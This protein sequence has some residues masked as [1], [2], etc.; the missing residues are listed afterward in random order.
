MTETP[1][2]YSE[3]RRVIAQKLEPYF[4]ISSMVP[5]NAASA[6]EPGM[7]EN[8]LVCSWADPETLTNRTLSVFVDPVPDGSQKA[9]D[10]REMIAEETLPTPDAHPSDAEAY[11]LPGR[12]PG[13][14]V[15][16]LNYLGRL[17]AIAGNCV[18]Q[19]MPWPDSV[20]LGELAE[21]ALD[22]ARTAGCSAYVDDFE[23][24]ALD[25]SK[26]S[27]AWSTADGWVYDPRTPPQQ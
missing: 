19:L 24:P 25:S 16:V 22:I 18:V 20:P 9:A 13:E 6:F 1:G 27:G 4:G 10:V 14:Y 7:F 8:S 12:N 5:T 17:T 21:V 3:R 23:P 2:S 26:A 11:E 15:F